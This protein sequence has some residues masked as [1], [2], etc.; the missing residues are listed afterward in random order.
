[1][2]VIYIV[3]L[4]FLW[5]CQVFTLVVAW[6]ALRKSP[7]TQAGK[8]EGLENW[9]ADLETRHESLHASHKKLNSRY[10]MAKAREVKSAGSQSSNHDTG[11]LLP[12][13]NET[14]AE[15]KAR[16]RRKI[17]TGELKHAPD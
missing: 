14:D 10:S 13:P 6:A 11:S 16:M 4:I 15:W 8:I 7:I 5:V 12:M 3:A 9:L 17:V 1:M 2:P